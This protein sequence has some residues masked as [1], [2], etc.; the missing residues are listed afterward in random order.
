MTDRELI[1]KLNTLKV[2]PDEAW[3][4][5][6][7]EILLSQISGGNEI[8][9]KINILE[10]LDVWSE[11]FIPFDLLHKLAA[12]PVMV[13]GLVIASLL[14]GG[15]FSLQAA[16]NTKPGDSLYIAKIV[17]EKA[18]TAITF[19]EKEKAKLGVEF[20]G[21]RAKE[22]VRVI[23]EEKDD[24][25]KNEKVEKL[26]ADFKKELSGAKDR[27]EKINSRESDE[28]EDSGSGGANGNK[29]E[30][31]TGENKPADEVFGANLG[32]D[33]N[34]IQVSDP[35]GAG[36]AKPG[37]PKTNSEIKPAD[38]A[39]TTAENEKP[40]EKVGAE[41]KILND[42]EKLFENKDYGGA[43]EKLEEIKNIIED[44]DTSQNDSATSTDEKV[45]MS[46]K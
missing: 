7:R 35:S 18:R 16:K 6:S 27:L 9:E 17:S 13:T 3:K 30:E 38:K 26:A 46:T 44:K 10:Q 22:M 28:P 15:I 24:S 25:A 32:K 14:G 34:G 19:D 20:A 23:E 36:A 12:K 29:E 43:A 45:E 5:R 40:V 39:T 41:V 1:A 33:N 8:A 31:K 37:A 11:V 42:A 2:K 4:N 21:N